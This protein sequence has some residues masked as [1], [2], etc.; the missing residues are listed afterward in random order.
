ML[1]LGKDTPWEDLLLCGP[2]WVLW[3]AM[4]GTMIPITRGEVSLVLSVLHCLVEGG[5]QVNDGRFVTS[6]MA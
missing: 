5:E 2:G 4:S 3:R 1:P 6:V